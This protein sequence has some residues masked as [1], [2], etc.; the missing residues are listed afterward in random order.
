[1]YPAE[2]WKTKL[3]TLSLS[4]YIKSDKTDSDK[5]QTQQSTPPGMKI[6]GLSSDQLKSNTESKSAAWLQ[7]LVSWSEWYKRD[8]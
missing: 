1:V 3:D 2:M 5:G 4:Q 7:A 6:P 8:D